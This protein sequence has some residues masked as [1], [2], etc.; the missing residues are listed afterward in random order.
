MCKG[1]FSG[2]TPLTKAKLIISTPN[3]IKERDITFLIDTGAA[4]TALGIVDVI[5]LNLGVDLLRE[6]R[7]IEIEGVS[8]RTNILTLKKPFLL[9]FEDESTVL[10]RRSIHFELLDELWILPKSTVSVL[11]RD[12]LNRFEITYKANED[13]II[14]RRDDFAE[15]CHICYSERI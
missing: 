13:K 8:G 10:N 2:E 11:G 15:G 14:M 12:I 9:R 3:G 6:L 7:K 4:K 5:R 1:F